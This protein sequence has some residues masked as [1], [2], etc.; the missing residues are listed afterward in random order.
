MGPKVRG[1]GGGQ[2][3]KLSSVGKFH[4]EP[5]SRFTSLD[6][7]VGER[8]QPIRH[9]KAERLLVLTLDDELEL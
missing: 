5:P 9:F 2:M 3:E 6:P 7:L 1:S 4:S 8:E